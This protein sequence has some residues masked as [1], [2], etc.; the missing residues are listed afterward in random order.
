MDYTASTASILNLFILSLDRYW[1]ITT[2]LKYLRKRT[3]KRA[4]LMIGIVWLMSSA[5]VLPI[6]C[7]HWFF[8]GGVR[9]Q[10]VDSVCET[11]FAN[12]VPFKVLKSSIAMI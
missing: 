9:R 11:E 1:S 8:F 3:K 12:D 6:L 2:P 4:G 10:P 7:W 5:W